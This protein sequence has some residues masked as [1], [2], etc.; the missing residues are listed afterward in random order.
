MRVAIYSRQSTENDDQIEAH[1]ARCRA[2]AQQERWKVVGEFR[3]NG[4]SGYE[5]GVKRPGYEELLDLIEAGK[6]DRVLAV[7]LDRLFR[8]DKERGRFYDRCLA[9]GVTYVAL[10]DEQ[11]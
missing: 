1:L 3:D 9:A 7:S 10:V 11:D 8:Q 2:R 6:V 4:K 5:R